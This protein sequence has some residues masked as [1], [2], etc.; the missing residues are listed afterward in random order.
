MKPFMSDRFQLNTG[1]VLAV[2]LSEPLV[3]NTPRANLL[4]IILSHELLHAQLFANEG[5]YNVMES[6]WVD[7]VTAVDKEFVLKKLE[8]SY[9]VSSWE[10]EP[11]ARKVLFNE[12]LA[13]LLMDL[14]CY[15]GLPFFK[16]DPDI[17]SK[18]SKEDQK[19]QIDEAK[20]LGAMFIQEYHPL[21]IEFIDKSLSFELED[22]YLLIGKDQIDSS[23][24]QV[25]PKNSLTR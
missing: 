14:P 5:L 16:V 7:I 6:F 19:K 25:C 13:Y 11:G 2:S 4:S 3:D 15:S 20:N 17:I 22:L 24:I 23:Q 10:T 9:E 21:L 1:V 18:L 8:K 12:L